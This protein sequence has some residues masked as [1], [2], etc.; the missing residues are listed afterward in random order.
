MPSKM[1]CFVGRKG[2]IQNYF[3]VAFRTLFR[4]KG[5]TLLNGAGLSVGIGACLMIFL[6]VRFELSYDNFHPD[7]DRIYRLVSAPYRPGS[8]LGMG[9]GAPLPAAQALRL[10]YPQLEKVAAIFGRDGQ[11]TVL[12][13]KKEAGKKFN[14][15]GD[16]YFAE[17]A[18]FDIFRF[19]WLAG[20][21]RTALTAPNTV[22]LSR[23][24]AV[25][26]FGD[27][28]TGVGRVIKFNNKE[29][30]QVTGILQ[31][32]PA[33]TDFPLKVVFSYSSLTNVDLTDWQGIYGRGY[34]FIRLPRGLAASRMNAELRDLVNR[35]TAAGRER[36][37]IE[38]QPL[39]DMH[40]DGRFGNYSGRTFSRELI[41]SLC[42]MA[43][44]LLI[45]ACVNF[46]NLATAQAV[47][48][49]QEVGIRKVLGST[50]GR[51][52]RQ[53][54][55]EAGLITLLAVAAALCLTATALPL[56]NDLLKTD[57]T[58]Q[59]SDPPLLGF[60]SL[61]TM[62]AT[63]M[64]GLYPALF[65][66]RCSPVTSL[67][68]K[69]TTNTPGGISLR[70][71]LVVLQFCI[72]QVM[73]ICVLVV[74]GQ[75][76]YFRHASLGFDKASI[77][78][79]PIPNDSLS[80]LKMN[81]V[82][83]EL[84]RIPGVQS[85]S[86]STFSPLDNDI[87]SNQFKFDHSKTKTDFQAYF[88]WADADFFQTY[89]PVLVAGR[90]YGP[91]DTLREFVVNETLVKKLGLRQPKDIL[92]KEINFWDERRAPVVGVV[93]DFH[94]NSMQ[95][96]IRPVVMGVWKETYGMAGIKLRPA[97]VGQSLAA[98]EKVW[99]AAYPDAVY[100]YQFLDEKIDNYYKEEGKLS[101]LYRVFA[102]IAILISCL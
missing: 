39:A 60:L 61:V 54:M 97:N 13:D 72:A 32:V 55:G 5:Y 84:L 44:F 48:R 10:E 18:F 24:T 51:L 93:R 78:N 100:S 2:M 95:D 45:I 19:H 36:R 20:D 49:S 75:T 47:R 16:V 59:L 12:D 14:E 71:G 65:L 67:K 102:G 86:F 89:Q 96:P 52:I 38:L 87:W 91:S 40:F 46:V 58:L 22:A 53:F 90:L 99:N 73:I 33:N 76:A 80:Q 25:K 63:L 62:A 11:V 3:K 70:R 85:V 66:S 43:A 8:P 101:V 41:A 88:K 42:L 21:P 69:L 50:R 92:G 26:Y 74:S 15:E 28:R 34:T 23:E 57:I 56:L 30:Y 82:R 68:N 6:L 83:Q 29:I 17:S 37:G 35:H 1:A 4:N 31:D 27:W 77:V 81:T 94:T 9:A 79:V 98:I 64:A 7:R